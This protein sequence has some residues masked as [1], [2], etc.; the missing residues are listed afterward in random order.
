MQSVASVNQ[1]KEMDDQGRAGEA[2]RTCRFCSCELSTTFIDLGMSPP[3]ENVRRPQEMDSVEHF[4]PLHVFVCERCWLVQ[5]REYIAP[6]DIFREYAYFSSMS[7]SWLKHA[8]DYS[9]KMIERFQLGSDHQVVEIAS[10]DGYL[11]KNFVEKH[12]PALGIE[13]ALNVAEVGRENGVPSINEFFGCEV[14]EK[15]AAQGTK[16]DLLLGN[17]VLAHVPDLNDFVGGLK[18]L[19]NSDGVVTMEFP[20]L[21]ELM[22]NRQ[23]D[24]IYHEH[25][26]YLSALTV[27]KVFAHHGLRLFDVEQ[28]AS[29]GGS[30]RVFATH[31]DSQQHPS[32]GAVERL[33]DFELEKGLGNLEAYQS[34]KDQVE[35]LKLDVLQFLIDAKRQ[36]KRVA[37]YGAPGKGVTLLNYMGIR[38]DLIEFTV[39]RNEYKQGTF[40][41]G[42]GIPVFAPTAIFEQKPDYVFILPWNLRKEIVEQMKSIKEWGGRFV[43][44]IPSLEIV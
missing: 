5:L 11:L 41:P 38:N 17:N 13:P 34:F 36:G 6:E 12:I 30:L 40:V 15:L 8:K 9:H 3:C 19:L 43:V 21:W 25:Y 42:T 44:P 37:G 2:K 1:A 22:E 32:T 35:S 33:I 16:A 23:F 29:H 18:I 7:D 28:L 10:N 20:H 39:D 4:Y 14:A 24:T 26:S 27:Q 31:Q